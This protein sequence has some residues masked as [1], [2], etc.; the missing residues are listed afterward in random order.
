MFSALNSLSKISSSKGLRTALSPKDLQ[1]LSQIILSGKIPIDRL[2]KMISYEAIEDFI[3]MV[4]STPE[5][6]NE[7]LISKIK[8]IPLYVLNLCMINLSGENNIDAIK[9]LNEIG[10]DID[11]DI[12]QACREN[13]ESCPFDNGDFYMNKIKNPLEVA[14]K[15]GSLEVM[16]YLINE[17]AACDDNLFKLAATNN[18]ILII[19]LLIENN[20]VD[21][22]LALKYASF[23]GNIDIVQSILKNTSISP[24][25]AEESLQISLCKDNFDVALY[26]LNSGINLPQAEISLK[27][28]TR[29]FSFFR[30]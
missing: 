8:M 16:N 12:S 4:A 7:E 26:L 15:H 1:C 17:G 14:A 10:C 22:V 3:A 6:K 2:C 18:H 20:L 5:Q 9:F 24:A 30:W 21:S 19:K 29:I 11:C 27:E 13:R 25:G 23:I 28:E